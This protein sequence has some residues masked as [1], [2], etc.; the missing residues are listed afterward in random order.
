MCLQ[1]Y[2]YNKKNMLKI[3]HFLLKIGLIN[4]VFARTLTTSG[5]S[6]RII[7]VKFLMLG[8]KMLAQKMHFLLLNFI[9]NKCSIY[10]N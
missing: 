1:K 2:L 4:Q 8:V 5:F 3:K 10:D 7:S 6:C 9:N